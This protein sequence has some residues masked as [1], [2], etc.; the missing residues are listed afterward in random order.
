MANFSQKEGIHLVNDKFNLNYQ[1]N[2]GEIQVRL[3]LFFPIWIFFHNHSRIT[4]LQ[5]KGEDISLTPHYHFHPLHRHLDISRAI[6]A[7]S[8]PLHIGRSRT[9]TFRPLM[10][11][12]DTHSSWQLT[13]WFFSLMGLS[14]IMFVLMKTINHSYFYWQKHTQ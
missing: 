3:F 5:G 11:L 13:A 12:N 1:D 4:R 7:E 14:D 6:T 8:S 10:S 2:H 9:R